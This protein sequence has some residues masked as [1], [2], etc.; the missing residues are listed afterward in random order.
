METRSAQEI[1]DAALGEL[2]IQVSKP[3]YRTWLEKTIGLSYQD[4]QFVVGV[5]TSFVAEYLD[6]NQYSLIE[7]TLIGLTTTPEIKVSF[8]VNGKHQSSLSTRSADWKNLPSIRTD[9]PIFK[10][11]YVFDSFIVGSCNHLAYAAAQAVTQNPGYSYNP[12][13]ICGGVGL[14]KTHL[15][16][17]IGH[18]ALANNIKVIYVTAEQFTNEFVNAIRERKTDEFRDKYRSSGMLLVDDIH[19]I[20]GKEQTAESFFHTFNAL[21]NANRQIVITS[22][23]PPKSM[24]FLEERLR[25]RFEWGLIVDIQPPEFETRLAILQ[26]KAKQREVN[27]TSDVLELIARQIRQNIRELE[28]SLNRVIA[29]A[30]L[31]RASPDIELATHAL[32]DIA[33]KEPKGVF[34][35]SSQVLE[36]VADSFQMKPVDLKGRTRDRGTTLARQVAM[37]LI[38]QETNSSL[39]QIG[40]EL[41]NRDHHLVSQAHKKIASDM[42]TDRG[43]NNK[44]LDIQ[45]RLHSRHR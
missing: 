23:Q 37:Y 27:I 17:A 20:S 41:G 15:L 11:N 21:H 31:L 32:K 34:L 14:G 40:K 25:S 45:Q 39:A 7:K 3:N 33:S 16:H 24:P 19:F 29:Y 4:N 35:T 43:L 8:Q 13:F 18:A 44:I 5:P 1:W 36:A 2:Q 22:D 38:R 26:S 10:S 28:G 9:S 42:T 6:K 12:L 30:R